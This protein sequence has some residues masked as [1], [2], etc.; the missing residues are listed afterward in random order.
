MKTL[1][2]GLLLLLV[3]VYS[4]NKHIENIQKK[5][6]IITRKTKKRHTTKEK[7]TIFH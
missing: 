7:L 2:L 3:A 6:L 5:K 4:F 1:I